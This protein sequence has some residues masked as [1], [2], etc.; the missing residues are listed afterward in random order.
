M[1]NDAIST[2]LMEQG[3]E[4][5]AF[6]VRQVF[7]LKQGITEGQAGRNTVFLRQCQNIPWVIVPKPH[8]ASAP[9]TVR[10]RAVDGADVTP[11]VEIFPV[12]PKKGQED[13]V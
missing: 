3:A 11:I 1:D 13:A 12:F 6:S 2:R 8:T 5:V 9:D 10:R 7:L 4:A